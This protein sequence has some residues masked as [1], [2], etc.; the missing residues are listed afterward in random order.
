MALSL[1]GRPVRRGIRELLVERAHLLKNLI[2]PRSFFRIHSRNGESHMYQDVV[3]DV[4]FRHKVKAD[5]PRNAAKR[6][7]SYG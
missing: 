3:S 6:N 2:S 5:I 7:S 1:F 4:Y